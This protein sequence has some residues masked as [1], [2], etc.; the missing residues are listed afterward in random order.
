M[1]RHPILFLLLL[2][3]LAAAVIVAGQRYM[4]ERASRSVAIVVDYDEVETCAAA[5]GITIDEALAKFRNAGVTGVGISERTFGDLVERGE[6]TPTRMGRMLLTTAASDP[7][8]LTFARPQI[9]QQAHD[10]LAA[11]FPSQLVESESGTPVE[12]YDLVVPFFRVHDYPSL[13]DVGIGLDPDALMAVHRAGLRVEARFINYPGI[14]RRAMQ[15]MVHQA[16]QEGADVVISLETEALGFPN[17]TREMADVLKQAGIADGWVEFAKQAGDQS[18]AASMQ[19]RIV[20]VHSIES[21]EI[22]TY[23]P[24]RAIE[25]YVRGVRERNVRM[26]YVRLFLAASPDPMTGNLKYCT[27][28]CRE[29]RDAGYTI[30]KPSLITAPTIPPILLVCIALGI[31]AGITLLMVAV[32]CIRPLHQILIAVVIGLLGGAAVILAQGPTT[33]LLALAAAII[34][35]SLG[36]IDA[37]RIQWPCEGK[38]WLGE[39]MRVGGWFIL[40]SLTSTIGGLLIAGLLTRVDYMTQVETFRGIKLAMTLPMLIVGAVYVTDAFAQRETIGDWWRRV[41]GNAGAFFSS[42]ILVW[43]AILVGL[44]MG[45]VVLMLTRGGNTPG[46]TA[47]AFELKTRSLLDT[48]LVVR[49]RTKEFLFG[50]PLLFLA[51]GL[52]RLGRPKYVTM[53]LILGLVGQ[54]SLINTFCHLHTP[55]VYTLIRTGNGVILGAIVGAALYAVVRKLSR[56]KSLQG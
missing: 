21:K 47:S 30:G 25:R 15:A 14:T 4:C 54:V 32:W 36:V 12:Q 18:L 44:A 49:P 7:W 29:I 46:V 43:Q 13:V 2:I 53:L 55:I 52:A 37:R 9:T 41:R 3:G 35:P 10:A 16:N 33:A 50:H 20:K 56:E 40:I 6:M 17:R 5:S 28:L 42:P 22:D 27:D 31:A 11:R 1:N 26:C 45:A 48:A 34:F 23:S 19:G 24:S 38:G 39:A 51:I 8:V